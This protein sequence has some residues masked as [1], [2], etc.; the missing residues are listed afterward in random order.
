[1][2]RMAFK[3]IPGARCPSGQ[4]MV[5]NRLFAWMLSLSLVFRK[6]LPKVRFHGLPFY[7]LIKTVAS[8]LP[9]RQFLYPYFTQIEPTTRCNLVCKFCP[10]EGS[11]IKGEDLSFG[12]F[13]KTVD[14]NPWLMAVLLQGLGEPLLHPGIEDMIRYGRSKGKYMGICTNGMGLSADRIDRLISSGLNYLAISVDG[15]DA[16]FEAMRGG[17]PFNL[18]LENLSEIRKRANGKCLTAFWMRLSRE[19]LDQVIPVLQLARDFGVE[20][21]HFQDLQYK[22]GPKDLRPLS[23]SSTPN[24]RKKWDLLA[25]ARRQAAKAGIVSTLDPVDRHEK[26]THCKWPWEGAYVDCWGDVW[27]CCV[28][29][30]MDSALGNLNTKPFADIWKGAQYRR[31]RIA[32]KDGPLPEICRDCRFL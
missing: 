20:H 10:R 11:P 7:V 28:A 13:K 31:F 25:L 17:A 6:V 9:A 22:H 29:W 4:T 15:T 19:N 5:E 32:L 2:E 18:L 26:R 3:G 14:S 12:T 1:M 30:G 16:A 24:G 21:I 8:F 23:L 27:P